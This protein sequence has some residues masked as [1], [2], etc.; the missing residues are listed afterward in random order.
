MAQKSREW[1]Q[2]SVPA[3]QLV[4]AHVSTF[5]F[6]THG[7]YRVIVHDCVMFYTSR[8][9][10]LCTTNLT[11]KVKNADGEDLSRDWGEGW[12]GCWEHQ[13]LFRGQDQSPAPTLRLSTPMTPLLGDLRPPLAS[14]YS[15]HISGGCLQGKTPVHIKTDS[16]TMTLGDT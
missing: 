4:R 3:Q 10:H 6:E 9:P 15:R 7:N 13:L 14:T 16:F 5:Y 11:A 12:P 1:S 2:Q 8:A